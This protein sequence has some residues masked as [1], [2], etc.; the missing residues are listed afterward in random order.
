M[1]E[2]SHFAIWPKPRQAFV[3]LESL[4][5]IPEARRAAFAEVALGVFAAA[6]P[7]DPVLL[8]EAAGGGGG[9]GSGWHG[10]LLDD[11]QGLDRDQVCTWVYGC[12][13]ET[14]AERV[15]PFRM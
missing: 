6:A 14:G 8:R 9:R 4:P 5:T 7:A 10:G 13:R 2:W 11:L 1:P 12:V 3:K 15:W